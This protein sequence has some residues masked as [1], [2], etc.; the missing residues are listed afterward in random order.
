MYIYVHNI[1]PA[2]YERIINYNDL[3]YKRH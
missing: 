2:Y 1:S 3:V